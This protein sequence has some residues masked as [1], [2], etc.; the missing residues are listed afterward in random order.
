MLFRS[1]GVSRSLL[2]QIFKSKSDPQTSQ[3]LAL[4]PT[5][6]RMPKQQVV[7]SLATACFDGKKIKDAKKFDTDKYISLWPRKPLKDTFDYEVVKLSAP[8]KQMKLSSYAST[9]E[10][11][12]YY[13]PFVVFLDTNG[14]V[15]EGAGGF[16]NHETAE[17][18]TSH[19]KIEG[20]IHIPSQSRY[21]LLT[22]LASAI[23]LENKA[24]TNQGQ[25]KLIAIR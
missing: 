6:F 18:F 21:M 3:V 19:E 25:L 15:L 5:Y 12:R 23:D 24:L 14:C 1:K 16:K 13:W 22:P 11:P 7:E 4:A 10:N 20:I 8:L 17:S 9:Q 2:N